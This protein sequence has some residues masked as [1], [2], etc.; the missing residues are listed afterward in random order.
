MSLS[1]RVARNAA[2]QA[3]L[4]IVCGTA[5][6]Q[7]QISFTYNVPLQPTNFVN[8]SVAASRFDPELGILVGIEFTLDG[9]LEGTAR[10]ESLDATPATIATSVQAILSLARPDLSLPVSVTPLAQF[11]DQASAFDGIIDFAGTSGFAH[12]GVVTAASANASSPPPSSDLLDFLGPPG[13]PGTITL[14]V[15]GI[16]SSSSSGPGNAVFEFMTSAGADV[17]VRYLYELDCND[18]GVPDDDDAA[19]ETSADCNMNGVPDEC[20]TT[21]GFPYCFGLVCP[22]ANPDAAAG[23]ANSSG[24]GGALAATGS[25]SIAADDLR[26]SG[27]HLIPTESAFL[28]SADVAL[29]SCLGRSFGDGL[30]CAGLNLIRLESK[31]SDRNGAV[32]FG[33]GLIAL[34]S[35]PSPGTERRYQL[36]YRDPTGPCGAGFNL[37]NGFAVTYTP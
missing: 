6:A 34:E 18:N 22:C 37:T 17:T 24:G 19:S 29:N 36:W 35:G 13:D 10:V 7:H 11:S 28:F 25:A 31:V 8:Q 16:G 9:R 3:G 15:G 20:E 14:P 21:P 32:T 26:L 1:S 23:C 33:P 4:A 27:T 30:R 2:L 5:R 12:A